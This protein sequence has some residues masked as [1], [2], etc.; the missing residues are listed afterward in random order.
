MSCGTS[1][2]SCDLSDD[3][4]VCGRHP[5]DGTVTPGSAG[6][7]SVKPSKMPVFDPEKSLEATDPDSEDP[8]VD[9]LV[10]A[11]HVECDLTGSRYGTCCVEDTP[12]IH[13]N[14]LPGAITG[15]VRT[16]TP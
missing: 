9:N 10:Y 14:E 5:A 11:E 7:L 1:A 13:P 15:C 12:T 8:D 3:K 16:K 2:T 6:A 4:K